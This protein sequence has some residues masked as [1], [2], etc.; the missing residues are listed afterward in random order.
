MLDLSKP[1]IYF[2]ENI[3][4]NK[5]YIGS[6]NRPLSVRLGE[7]KRKLK[8]NSHPCG[9]LQNDFNFF[10]INN[11]S[12]QILENIQDLSKIR[13]METQWIKSIKPEYNTHNS[14]R[15]AV[16][17][18]QEVRLRYSRA[19]GGK[20]FEAYDLNGNFIKTFDLQTDCSRELGIKQSN[21]WSCLNGKTDTI[22]GYR[23]KYVG[24]DFKFI[25]ASKKDKKCSLNMAKSKFKGKLLVYKNNLFIG[26]YDSPLEASIH[27]NLKNNYIRNKLSKNKKNTKGYFF[28]KE[29]L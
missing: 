13:L 11:F 1:G 2:I 14:A 12:F 5:I 29:E 9:A 25:P 15:K 21:L 6:T 18:T 26:K 22:K 10:G 16:E 27:L 28:I 3:V 7:H 20:S 23:F 8:S 17:Y 4:N 24:E 19:K